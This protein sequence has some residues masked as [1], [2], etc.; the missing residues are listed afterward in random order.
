MRA[1]CRLCKT[2]LLIMIMSSFVVKYLALILNM[3]NF[4]VCCK[5]GSVPCCCCE[6]TIYFHECII[7][8]CELDEW[9]LYLSN[10][11]LHTFK[12][13][14]Y[15]FLQ[16]PLIPRVRLR[17]LLGDLGG[18]HWSKVGFK[19]AKTLAVSKY[20]IE[21]TITKISS[22]WFQLHSFFLN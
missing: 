4:Y 5:L 15:W 19:S 12:T 18:S 13:M 2:F 14:K 20:K 7:L 16:S 6:C 22:R 1:L 17:L 9:I 3:V 10:I 11:Y 8:C 21:K